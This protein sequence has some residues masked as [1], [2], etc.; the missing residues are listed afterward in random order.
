[1]YEPN[2]WRR[3]I[4]RRLPCDHQDPLTT[5]LWRAWRLG[6]DA[7][8]KGKRPEAAKS[9]VQDFLDLC[10]DWSMP[11]L[12]PDSSLQTSTTSAKAF[13]LSWSVPKTLPLHFTVHR[14]RTLSK[15]SSCLKFCYS[16]QLHDSS[17]TL[18]Q[19]TLSHRKNL[20]YDYQVQK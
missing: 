4:P 18:M 16:P 11:D 10:L 13:K 17:G 7:S 5:N 12:H 6:L 9:R 2:Q 15:R 19:T 20:N 1:M 3:P 14:K 8:Q